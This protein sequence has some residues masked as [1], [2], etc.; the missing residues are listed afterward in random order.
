MLPIMVNI[1]TVFLCC[2]GVF[3]C[4]SWFW[5]EHGDWSVK[6]L[7]CETIV[8]EKVVRETATNRGGFLL[9]GDDMKGLLAKQLFLRLSFVVLKPSFV[10]LSC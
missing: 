10:K 2:C 7:F 5:L 3:G 8:R 1:A 6:R 9:E 4:P